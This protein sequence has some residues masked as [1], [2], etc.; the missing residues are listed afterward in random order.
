[1]QKKSLFKAITAAKKNIITISWRCRIILKSQQIAALFIRPAI[2]HV[3]FSQFA[4]I[5]DR[6]MSKTSIFRPLGE[7]STTNAL[8]YL[9]KMKNWKLK[10]QNQFAKFSKIFLQIIMSNFLNL[11]WLL[12]Y[13]KTL[14][15]HALG[16]SLLNRYAFQH[17]LEM[18]IYLNLYLLLLY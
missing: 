15:F 5:A 4:W 14:Y 6:H 16:K 1:M 17:L 10:M 3:Q 8:Q 9:L 13:G 11:H 18:Q 2:H 7:K 12:T